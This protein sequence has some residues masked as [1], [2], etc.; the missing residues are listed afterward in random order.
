MLASFLLLSSPSQVLESQLEMESIRTGLRNIM[1][2]L[3]R[4][5]PP[6]EAALLA[7]P[8]VCGK[9]VAARTRAASF[10][11]GCLTIEVSDATWAA[12]LKSFSSSYINGFQA[13]LGP[14][15]KEVK[16]KISR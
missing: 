6:E 4:T 13:L 10:A 7:W 3:L 14:M 15:V 8:V 12:Q 5:R 2:E 16:F 9:D 1:G 11:D